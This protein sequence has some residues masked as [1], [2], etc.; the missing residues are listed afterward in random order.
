[1]ENLRRGAGEGYFLNRRSQVRFLPTARAAL[2]QW[3]EQR[4]SITAGADNSRRK[5]FRCGEGARYFDP[6]RALRCKS[7]RLRTRNPPASREAVAQPNHASRSFPPDKM[8]GWRG[9]ELLRLT[10]MWGCRSA[11]LLNYSSRLAFGRRESRTSRRFAPGDGK[12]LE[13]RRK[14]NCLCA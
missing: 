5:K 7:E 2:A 1:L 8:P 4:L 3:I 6:K 12:P 14:K 9:E 13:W 11:T 10:T